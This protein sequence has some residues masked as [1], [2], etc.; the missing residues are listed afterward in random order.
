MESITYFKDTSEYEDY[1]HAMDW[2]AYTEDTN[3]IHIDK[4][5]D[6]KYVI[7]AE[8]VIDTLKTSKI[9]TADLTRSA[10]FKITDPD[11]IVSVI[12]P[13]ENYTFTKTGTY[14]IDYGLYNPT[15]M[16]SGMFQ[17]CSNLVWF[18]ADTDII[19]V[20]AVA[21][22]SCSNFTGCLFGD[23]YP[24]VQVFD[25]PYD[26]NDIIF[27]GHVKTIDNFAN[28]CGK[29]R[30]VYIESANIPMFGCLRA[31]NNSLIKSVVYLGK[32]VDCWYYDS[33][34]RIT[35][36][37]GT[38]FSNEDKIIKF[39]IHPEHSRF[40]YD[41]SVAGVLDKG[42]YPNQKKIL[43]GANKEYLKIPSGYTINSYETYRG[44]FG[45]K[46]VDLSEYDGNTFN[47][48][49]DSRATTFIL[50]P[51]INKLGKFEGGKSGTQNL[52]IYNKRAPMVVW[53]NDW[54]PEY[55][56]RNHVGGYSFFQ[57]GDNNGSLG[58]SNGGGYVN[59][60]YTK[61]N[62]YILEGTSEEKATWTNQYDETVTDYWGNE[63][64]N[65]WAFHFTKWEDAPTAQ[66][67]DLMHTLYN[68][69]TLHFYTQEQ[70]D[71]LV[72]SIVQIYNNN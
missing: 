70:L 21:V 41:E 35:R 11:G 58:S 32:D 57:S 15:K 38:L 39:I 5:K 50:G 22:M 20:E 72:N 53:G 63:R 71:T 49:I 4:G 13:V 43:F 56:S 67:G 34:H 44:R 33:Q 36:R 10:K 25:E 1:Y 7:H 48:F 23:N 64:P 61:R 12:N 18:K 3:L 46:I 19:E 16:P 9:Y 2:V 59:P 27:L 42:V 55:G 26:K 47:G 29:V 60:D 62:T 30:N 51:N 6:F 14:K 40:I 24:E 28:N 68:G 69:F 31:S 45:I 8:F 66:R 17:N 37:Y 65:V 52:I 54:D